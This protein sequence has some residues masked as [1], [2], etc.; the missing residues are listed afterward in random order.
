MLNLRPPPTAT[1]SRAKCCGRPPSKPAVQATSTEELV[2]L[3]KVQLRTGNGFPAATTW[4]NIHARSVLCARWE[5]VQECGKVFGKLIGSDSAVARAKA[6]FMWLIGNVLNKVV[7]TVAYLLQNF[8]LYTCIIAFGLLRKSALVLCQPF[9]AASI[10]SL[11]ILFQRQHTKE[12]KNV[13]AY[14]CCFQKGF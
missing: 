14:I 2:W 13:D 8:T 11:G 9:F 6:P 10:F 5:N 1:S 12:Y 7:A 3:K 4:K